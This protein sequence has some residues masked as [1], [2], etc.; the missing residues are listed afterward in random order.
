M[1]KAAIKAAKVD[2]VLP[3]AEIGPF[4]VLLDNDEEE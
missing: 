1:P 4:L 3:L 2:H